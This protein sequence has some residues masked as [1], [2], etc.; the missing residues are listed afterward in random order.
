M[1]IIIHPSINLLLSE[2]AIFMTTQPQNRIIV[3]FCI[4]VYNNSEGAVKIVKALLSSPDTRFEVVV[5][6]NASTDNVQELLAQIHD[7]RFKYFR[8]AQNLGAHKNWLHSLELGSGEWLYLIRGRDMMCGENI[9]KLIALL[10]QAHEN[11]VLYLKDHGHFRGGLDI[12]SGIDAMSRFVG[13]NHQ[14]GEIFRREEFMAIPEA[15]R[16]HYFSIGD[17]YPENFAIRDLLLKG[18]GAFIHSGVVGGGY[19]IDKA[20]V[21]S[22]VEYGLNTN[23]SFLAPPRRTKQFFEVVDMIDEL[24]ERFTNIERDEYFKSRYYSLLKIVSYGCRIIFRDP[25]QMAHYGQPVRHISIPE[26]TRYILKAYRD[27]KAHLKEKGTYSFRRQLIMS[28]CTP[29]AIIH[30]T[31]KTIIRDIIEP[32]GIWKILHRIRNY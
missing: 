21:V 5:S 13:Y 26:M 17:M 16:Q 3:S 6:D 32:L 30:I 23:D 10:E 11:G 19:A 4:P 1:C 27:T 22:K 2:A 20:K 29:L 28:F 7:P 31:T 12:H 14:T 8:N 18:K 24:P 9:H 25:V 15:A